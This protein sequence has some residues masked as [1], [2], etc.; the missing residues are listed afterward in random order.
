MGQELNCR[1]H[2]R[3]RVLEGKA[4]LETDYILFRGTERLKILLKDVSSVRAAAG[5]LQLE[6]EGGPAR[7]ELGAAAEKWAKKILHPPSRIEKLGVKAGLAVRVAG[8]FDREFLG[9]LS[10]TVAAKGPSDLIFVAA[11]SRKELIKID[12]LASGLKPAGAIWVVYP[13][14]V[15]EIREI[16]VLEAGRAAGLTDVKVASFSATHTALKF[17]IPLVKRAKPAGG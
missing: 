2:Y 6:F 16:E 3:K 9:E 14:G 7:L 4:Y 12:K 10:G 13:K 5:L 15:P 11:R 8:E 1:M 17:M